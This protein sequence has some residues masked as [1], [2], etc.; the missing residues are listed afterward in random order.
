MLRKSSPVH[1]PISEGVLNRGKGP[2]A[3]R[4]FSGRDCHRQ[5]SRLSYKV[6]SQLSRNRRIA[7]VAVAL[8]G[9][10][11]TALG[12]GVSRGND[13]MV[14]RLLEEGAQVEGWTKT[15]A[16]ALHQATWNGHETVVRLLLEKGANIETKDRSGWTALIRA[17]WNGHGP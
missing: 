15:G 2:L 1:S 16:T 4:F 7:Y 12:A 9:F 6:L 5:G 11:G 10:R 13:I 14:R 8:L 17:A 3:P